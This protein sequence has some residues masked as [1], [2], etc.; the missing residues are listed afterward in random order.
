MKKSA[1]AIL[2]AFLSLAAK[3]QNPSINEDGKKIEKEKGE[4]KENFFFMD[5]HKSTSVH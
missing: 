2:M 5:F 3:A 1:L 4:Q